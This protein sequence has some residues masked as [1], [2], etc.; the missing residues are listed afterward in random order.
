MLPLVIITHPLAG[1]TEIDVTRR[2][3]EAYD[4]IKR[5]LT[6]GTNI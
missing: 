5:I 1:T 4:Q 2:A 3:D 6:I